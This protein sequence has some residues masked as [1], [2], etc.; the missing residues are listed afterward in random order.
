[1]LRRS[2]DRAS[3]VSAGPRSPPGFDTKGC[4]RWRATSECLMRQC[5]GSPGVSSMEAWLIK[6]NDK[7]L[8]LERRAEVV[9]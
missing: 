5:A 1:M 7:S 6:Q 3:P 4:E 9:S 2:K 8:G